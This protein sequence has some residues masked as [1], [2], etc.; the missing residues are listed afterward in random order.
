MLEGT[1]GGIVVEPRG[2]TVPVLG[3]G[4]GSI[5]AGAVVALSTLGA[6]PATARYATVY[7]D[8][9]S[10][11][12]RVDGTDPTTALGGL[13]PNPGNVI[14]DG[15]LANVKFIATAGTAQAYVIYQ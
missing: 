15:N 5:G 12:F 13:V 10:V 1:S 6:I 8:G 2:S 3:T 4:Q 9:A 11:R 14:F 7:F